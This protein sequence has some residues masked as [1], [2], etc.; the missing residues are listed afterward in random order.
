MP[1]LR[2]SLLA[3]HACLAARQ[4]PQ[5]EQRPGES[6]AGPNEQGCAL[7]IRKRRVRSGAQCPGG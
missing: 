4:R 7:G 1:L 3:S 6:N 2:L 5:D